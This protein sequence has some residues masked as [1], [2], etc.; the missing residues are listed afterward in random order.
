MSDEPKNTEGGTKG[1]EPPA[2]D[3]RRGHEAAETRGHQ[4]PENSAQAGH[5]A[6]TDLELGHPPAGQG[7]TMQMIGEM[8]SPAEEAPRPTS[9]PPKPADAAQSITPPSASSGDE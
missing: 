7:P 5:A 4:P 1:H 2:P 8:H 9:A 6:P 3:V